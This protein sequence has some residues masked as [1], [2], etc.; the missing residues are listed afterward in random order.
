MGSNADL[1]IA[2]S[3]DVPTIVASE[4]PLGTFKGINADGLDPLKLAVLHSL[5]TAKDFSD[6]LEHYQ[7]IA[8]ASTRGPWLIKLPDELITLLANLAPQDH[9]STTA[10]WASTDQVEE[11]WWSEQDAEQFFARIVHCSQSAVFEGKDVFL[12]IYN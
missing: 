8:E 5:V 12:W 1:I 7:P 4:Y 10:K 11:E 9:A 3:S 2:S 6:L